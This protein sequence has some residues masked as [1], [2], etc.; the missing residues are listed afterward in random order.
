M[1]DWVVDKDVQL[2]LEMMQRRIPAA[3][4]VGVAQAVAQLSPMLW[5]HFEAEPVRAV[6]FRAPSLLDATPRVATGCA[7]EPLHAGDGSAGEATL[8]RCA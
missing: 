1:S 2:V 4:L 8:P 3:R 5:G 6:E 7:P